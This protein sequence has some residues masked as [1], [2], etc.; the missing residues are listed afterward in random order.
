MLIVPPLSTHL[1]YF[2][3]YNEL[4]FGLQVSLNIL[5]KKSIPFPS[6]KISEIDLKMMNDAC[7]ICTPFDPIPFL[8]FGNLEQIF[9]S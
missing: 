6:V 5:D 3:S 7:A 4:H 9:A 8:L 2:Y 1:S